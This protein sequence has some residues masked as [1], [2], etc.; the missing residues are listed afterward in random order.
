MKEIAIGVTGND[1]DIEVHV[2]Q[3]L[4]TSKYESGTGL[5]GGIAFLA[6]AQGGAAIHASL[7]VNLGPRPNEPDSYFGTIQGSDLVTQLPA[8]TYPDGTVIW[9]CARFGSDAEAW[10]PLVVRRYGPVA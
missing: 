10:E 9:R 2:K 6:S 1:F 3:K 8:G 5:T 4:N 7:S